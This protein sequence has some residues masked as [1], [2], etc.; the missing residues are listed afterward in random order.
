MVK[1]KTGGVVVNS[2]NLISAMSPGMKKIIKE[3]FTKSVRDSQSI[4]SKNL[5]P[6]ETIP[7]YL[8]NLILYNIK[9]F[10]MLQLEIMSFYIDMELQERDMRGEYE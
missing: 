7:E 1:K 10:S 3:E 4:N 6:G 2:S 5:G 8:K 9:D